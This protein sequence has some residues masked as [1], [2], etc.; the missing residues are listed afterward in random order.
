MGA[1]LGSLVST[2]C[3]GSRDLGTAP[4]STPGPEQKH[5]EG[6]EADH[7]LLAAGSLSVLCVN[8]RR[9]RRRVQAVGETKGDETSRGPRSAGAQTAAGTRRRQACPLR[10]V[11]LHVR[12]P[13]YRVRWSLRY[14]DKDASA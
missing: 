7:Q 5:L 6:G 9:A 4:S 13:R 12:C 10:C 3:L 2:C 14:Q 8:Q 11:S 1:G